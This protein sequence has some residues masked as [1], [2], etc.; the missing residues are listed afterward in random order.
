MGTTI[1]IHNLNPLYLTRLF[2]VLLKTR[3]E[4]QDY[5]CH[6]CKK[7][8]VERGPAPA[9]GREELLESLLLARI[10]LQGIARIL[11]VS[12]AWVVKRA[13]QLW[14][15][16]PKELPLGELTNPELCCVSTV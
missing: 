5:H 14:Q 11:K 16:V 4:N 12:L 1:G 13:K 2:I 6:Y 10:S 9:F 3:Y 15:A 7:Q 8:W